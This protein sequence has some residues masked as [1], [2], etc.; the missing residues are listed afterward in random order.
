[1]KQFVIDEL[2]PVDYGRL[3]TY[4]DDH[5]GCAGIDGIYW[6]AAWG[7]NPSGMNLLEYRSVGVLK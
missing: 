2:R 5:Y 3:K 6:I 4:L 1:M 7:L